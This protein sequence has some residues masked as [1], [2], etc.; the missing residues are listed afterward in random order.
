VSNGRTRGLRR[1][2]PGIGRVQRQVLRL[3]RIRDEISTAELVAWCYPRIKPGE[4]REWHWYNARRAA[5]RFLVR[6][7]RQGRH[8]LWA[9]KDPPN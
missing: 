3:G 2:G 1:G 8:L 9:P 5:E 4:L 6:V 7:G